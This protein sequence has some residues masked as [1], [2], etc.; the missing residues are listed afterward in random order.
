M[1]AV[2]VRWYEV[3]TFE[4]DGLEKSRLHR[5][6]RPKCVRSASASKQI[7]TPSGHYQTYLGILWFPGF[8]SGS[9]VHYVTIK[10]RKRHS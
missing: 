2:S 3:R 9:V 8:W 1:S 10:S 6:P 7:E 4:Q 5:I